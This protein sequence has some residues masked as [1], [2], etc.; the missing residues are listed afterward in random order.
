[1]EDVIDD[2]LERLGA[3]EGDDYDDDCED[4][5]GWLDEIDGDDEEEV[6]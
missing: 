4:D 6:E 2:I 1:M 3:L 5:E